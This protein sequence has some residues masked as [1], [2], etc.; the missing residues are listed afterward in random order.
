MGTLCERPRAQSA[1]RAGHPPDGPSPAAFTAAS[2]TSAVSVE[3]ADAVRR[4][5]RA[6]R[7]IGARAVEPEVRRRFAGR[8]T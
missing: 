1:R 4:G 3:E 6:R 2:A 5:A 7:P 8:V